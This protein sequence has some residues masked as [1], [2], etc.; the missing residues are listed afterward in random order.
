MANALLC[1]SFHNRLLQRL[2]T[3]WRTCGDEPEESPALAV[4]A[5]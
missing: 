1:N 4:A 5:C 2:L 3:D